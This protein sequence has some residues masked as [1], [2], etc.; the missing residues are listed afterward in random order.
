[1]LVTYC[2]PLGLDMNKG[3]PEDFSKRRVSLASRKARLFK[4]RLFKYMVER[5]VISASIA[6][7]VF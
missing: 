3:Y 7:K 1:M 6:K 4:P 2:A 5:H